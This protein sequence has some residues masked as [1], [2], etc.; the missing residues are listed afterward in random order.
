M[1]KQNLLLK[2]KINKLSYN[3]KFEIYNIL[4]KSNQKFS[5]NKN[6][7]FFNLK[8]LNQ[9]TIQSIEQFLNYS[10]QINTNIENDNEENIDNHNDINKEEILNSQYNNYNDLH[11]EKIETNEYTLY[12]NNEYNNIKKK[13]DMNIHLEDI[14]NED[15]HNENQEDQEYQEDQEDNVDNDDNGDNGDNVDNVDNIYVKSELEIEL[16][17]NQIEYGEDYGIGLENKNKN[18]NKFIFK[19]YMNKLNLQSKEINVKL[20]NQTHSTN[21]QPLHIKKSHI[22]T[23][24]TGSKSRIYNICK[25]IHKHNEYLN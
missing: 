23:K 18:K 6:G 20:Y 22:H 12:N 21:V 16:D 7:I 2:K 3:Q 14:Y 19:N 13:D 4:V 17:N 11:T 5:E 1:N 10:S 9:N 15:E 25:N 24:L 8:Y